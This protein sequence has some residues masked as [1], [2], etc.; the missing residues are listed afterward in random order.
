MGRG[1]RLDAS[2]ARLQDGST[3]LLRR[4]AKNAGEDEHGFTSLD[5]GLSVI[6]EHPKALG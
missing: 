6:A 4:F 1:L 5:A 3:H 2:T